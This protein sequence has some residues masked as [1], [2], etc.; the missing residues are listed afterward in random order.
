MNW[1]ER[2]GI[3]GAYFWGLVIGWLWAISPCL[4]T[5][6]ENSFR[7][8]GITVGFSFI[9]IGYIVSA[10]QQCLY[11]WFP[12]VGMSKSA[13]RKANKQLPHEVGDE[14][15]IEAYTVILTTK[16]DELKEDNSLRRYEWIREWVRKRMDVIS[17]D[18]SLIIVTI[19]TLIAALLRLLLSSS[20]PRPGRIALMVA[21]SV[22]ICFISWW[23]KKLLRKQVI[24]VIKDCYERF[25]DE[26]KN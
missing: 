7:D 12:R 4:L 1:F 21:T 13:L 24:I 20:Q 2:Y 16:T 11:L 9:P 10:L 15:S 14:L 22:V 23:N 18:F 8:I 25:L 5:Q 3:P 26:N 19:L 17:I 6:T